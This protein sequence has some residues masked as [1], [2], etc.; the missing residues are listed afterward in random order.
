MS[1]AGNP[2]TFSVSIAADVAWLTLDRPAALNA[3]TSVMLRELID[4]LGKLR[5]DPAVRV[6]VVTGA[7]RGFCAGMDLTDPLTGLGAPREERAALTRRNMDELTNA[8]IRA[9]AGF[10]K[11]TIAAVN[12]VAAGGGVGI[13]LAADIVIAAESASFVQVFT[14]KLGLISD[15]GVSWHLP[16]L[17]GRARAKGL[18]MLGDRLPARDAADWGM[19]WKCVPDD[20]LVAEVSAIAAR[21]A[22]GP[23]SALA[24]LGEAVDLGMVN[25]LDEQLD[26]ERDVN[27]ALNAGPD[28]E[29]GVAAFLEKRS[30]QFRST[31]IRAGGDSK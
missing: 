7:G 1:D 17:V 18:L 8:A 2:S 12:G 15:L 28:F 4:T 11:P 26:H 5:E 13:A 25:T 20:R 21:L 3:L 19:I 24:K 6:L 27:A 23:A 16:R 30:P 9:I 10:G 29:E 31:A 14:P 22:D